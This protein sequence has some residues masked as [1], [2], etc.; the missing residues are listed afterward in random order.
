MSSIARGKLL[1]IS[2][3]DKQIGETNA[4][5][6]VLLNNTSF[7]QNVKSVVTK[8]ISF[9]HVFPNIYEG[10]QTLF[11]N[12]DSVDYDIVVPVG[13][14][15]STSLIASINAQ[16][17]AEAGIGSIIMSEYVDPLLS[18][19]AQNTKF[20]FT[21]DLDLIIYSKDNGNSMADI[22][23]VEVE[24][25]AATVVD[26][27]YL[28][29]LGGLQTVYLCS[30]ELAGNNASASSNSGEQVQVV[31]EI[32]INVSFGQTV[33]YRSLDS[34]LDSI[35][36]PGALNLTRVSLSLC[37]RGGQTL[38]LQQNNLTCLFKI[39]GSDFFPSN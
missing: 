8:S 24:N 18:S 3:E 39:I 21:S 16:M 13:W 26:M 33:F 1:R 6:S 36:Y 9:K 11:F 14:Y 2:S 27:G 29:D 23:G 25:V 4:N 17:V 7:V 28:P 20:R 34:D 10:N 22:I 15:N 38:D 5:F 30:S 31:T 32:P 12:Y 37:T 35:V 19:T